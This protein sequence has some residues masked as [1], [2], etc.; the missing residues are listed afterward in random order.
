MFCSETGMHQGG[1][2]DGDILLVDS[3]SILSRVIKWFLEEGS[4]KAKVSHAE[5]LFVMNEFRKDYLEKKGVDVTNCEVGDIY[6]L[7]AVYKGV[8]AAE[9][10]PSV[11]DGREKWKVVRNVKL[12]DSAAASII[13]NLLMLVGTS[14]GFRRLAAHAVDKL[15]GTRLVYSLP[16]S[17][18]NCSQLVAMGYYPHKCTFEN[19]IPSGVTPDDI[20]DEANRNSHYVVVCNNGVKYGVC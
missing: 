15:L 10:G 8:R 4:E 2:K 3:G 6:S 5:V 11:A 7:G 19:K 16:N 1:I 14:Y 20:D 9:F 13:D 17:V 12:T 18:I